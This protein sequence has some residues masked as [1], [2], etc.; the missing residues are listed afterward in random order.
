ME[1]IFRL[2]MYI[3]PHGICF[4]AYIWMFR[5]AKRVPHKI[6]KSV[7]LVIIVA[8]FLYT[9]Y[10]LITTINRAYREDRFHFIILLIMVF[11]LFFAAI[12]MALGE[13]EK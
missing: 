3:L 5:K 9:L 11:V 1:T 13:P 10:H 4:A 12:F 6:Y 2:F 7:S 8:G